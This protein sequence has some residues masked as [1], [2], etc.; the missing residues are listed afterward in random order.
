MIA[1]AFTEVL[2]E[3]IGAMAPLG[4]VFAVYFGLRLFFI[5]KKESK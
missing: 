5:N 4:I 2:K 3:F 1:Q